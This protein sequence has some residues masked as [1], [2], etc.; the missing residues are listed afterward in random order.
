MQNDPKEIQENGDSEVNQHEFHVKFIEVSEQD[1]GEDGHIDQGVVEVVL[2]EQQYQLKDEKDNAEQESKL[3]G[4]AVLPRGGHICEDAAGSPREEPASVHPARGSAVFNIGPGLP[5]ELR[6]LL[7]GDLERQ[8]EQLEVVVVLH[9]SF[10]QLRF[11]I[12]VESA[13]IKL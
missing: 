5:A 4:G 6:L 1:D 7:G 2:V 13:S 10:L 12:G 8:R 9:Q 3:Q 11:P